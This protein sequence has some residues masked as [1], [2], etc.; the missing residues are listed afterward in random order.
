M[1]ARALVVVLSALVLVPSASAAAP[2]N[3]RGFLLFPGETQPV[4]RAFARTPA[5][6]WNRVAG[7]NRYE[8]QLSTSKTF[9]DN[10]I[11]WEN[12]YVKGPLTNVPL[13]LPWITGNPYSFYARVRAWVN[14][15]ATGW[16]SAYGF[17]MRAAAT[18]SSLSNGVNPRPGLLRWTPVEG[19]TAYQVTFLYDLA[20]GKKKL[21]KTG[22][23]AVDLREYY[24]F[25]HDTSTFGTIYWRVRAVRE[26][27][28]KPR[29][30]I[31]VVSYGAWSAL[32]GTDEPVFATGTVAL[33]GSISRSGGSDVVADDATGGLHSLVPGFWWNG[34][35]SLNGNGA[36][37]ADVAAL[38]VDCPLYHVYVYTDSDCVNRVH[39]SDLVGSP[40]YVPR[41]S[42]VLDLPATPDDLA[43]APNVFLADTDEEPPVYDAGGERVYAAGTNTPSGTGEEEEETTDA[44]NKPARTTGLWD[45]DW[46]DSRYWWTAVPA[47]PRI[48]PEATVEYQDVAFGEDNC[49]AGD[50]L[51]F[52][53]TSAP[54][55]ERASGIPYVSG[56]TSAGVRRATTAKP[57]F[58]G[59][60]LVAWKPAPGARKYQIQWS[61]RAYPWTTAG[62]ITRPATAAL[63]SVPDGVW[64]YRIRGI[65]STIPGTMQGMTWSDPQ[66]VRILPRTFS[67]VG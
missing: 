64:Y 27:E 47:I 11:V 45:V 55:T 25:V 59:R 66:Y 4:P 43:A 44:D 2:E 15:D 46:P 17:N 54:V 24:T 61:R 53:K 21:V 6:A 67:V 20:N 42:G 57:S 52:G 26:L 32:N 23:T 41:L 3:L 16:S 5:F 58:Y 19:A 12:E 9:A 29:N 10:A 34:D 31:P 49:I 48:T 18:P 60:V 33:D 38:G 65:D 13:T 39:N 30:Q 35:R 28:G 22:T 40:A 1:L 62:S 36:C 51:P 14:G 56:V 37:P 50:V 8:F 7:A 63:L